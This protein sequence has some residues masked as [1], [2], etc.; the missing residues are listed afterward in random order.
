MISTP[1]SSTYEINIGV[2]PL[3]NGNVTYPS[4]A[5]EKFKQ[6]MAKYHQNMAQMNEME[7]KL[8]LNI[9]EMNY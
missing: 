9:N 4:N 2:K 1:D 8:E 7:Q 3:V 6:R 5:S